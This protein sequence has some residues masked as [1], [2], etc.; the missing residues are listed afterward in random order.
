MNCMT[1]SARPTRYREIEVF[2]TPRQLG[3]QI[4]EAAREEVRGFVDSALHLVHKTAS[5]S[6]ERATAVALASTEQAR[7]YHPDLVLELEGIAAA[8]GV[9]LADIMLLQIRNQ[10]PGPPEN[11]CTSFSV[12]T[13]Q[14]GRPVHMAGQNWDS[15]PELDRFTLVITRRP[16]GKPAF[17]NVSQAGLIAYIGLSD[18]GFGVCLNT[19]PSPGRG[20]GVPH[21]FMVRAI[22]ESRGLEEA[23]LQVTRAHRAIGANIMLATPQGPANLEV[24]ID[25]VRVLQDEICLTH[26]NHCLHA[27]F[28]QWNEIYP[29]L[30]E[31][32]PRKARI[33]QLLAERGFSLEHLQTT[34]RDHSDYPRSICRH[35][36]DDPQHGFWAT[37]FSVV[38]DTTNA[39]MYVARGNPCVQPYETYPLSPQATSFNP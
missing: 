35:T 3:E 11:A 37:V 24:T 9:S 26:T 32:H 27:D 33:D 13:E 7:A 21:Y 15:D 16:E 20:I 6:R 19:L 18:Q 1:E 17:M 22:Y 25:Q 36:N 34:L 5:V 31:S 38:L 30:I 29:E 2:G 12:V 8:A 23:V 14:A 4:G 39:Q 10:L 28:C